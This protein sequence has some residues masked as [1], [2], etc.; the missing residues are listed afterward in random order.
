MIRG[1]PTLEE[2]LELLQARSGRGFVEISQAIAQ[3]EERHVTENG[4]PSAQS[5]LEIQSVAQAGFHRWADRAIADLCILLSAGNLDRMAV[6]RMAA[7]E[8][9]AFADKIRDATKAESFGEVV[10]AQ[11]IGAE[12]RKFALLLTAK[13]RRFE[14]GVLEVPKV[15]IA[16]PEIKAAKARTLGSHSLARG[17]MN[18][19]CQ[20]V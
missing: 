12:R 6:S 16:V 3:I 18:G 13:L 4:H 10:N 17:R 5:F 15:K 7:D 11:S 8:L 9:G 2:C 14:M 19:S 20:L 1:D